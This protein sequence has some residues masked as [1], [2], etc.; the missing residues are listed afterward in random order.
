MP[1]GNDASAALAE[2]A[3]KFGKGVGN[4]EELIEATLK[5][6][7]QELR[8]AELLPIDHAATDALNLGELS[9]PNG[10]PVRSATVR[11]G[12]TVIVYED[13][14]GAYRLAAL[15][16]TGDVTE[17]GPKPKPSGRKVGGADPKE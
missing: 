9:G 5:M 3:D 16:E 14:R 8:R 10:E 6:R 13:S 15:D 12:T 17:S 4:A 2:L 11:G 7:S 1:R